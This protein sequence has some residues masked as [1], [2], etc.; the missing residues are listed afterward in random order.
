MQYIFHFLTNSI[1][2]K[3]QYQFNIQNSSYNK[4][5][6]ILMCDP[7]K[8]IHTPWIQFDEFLL[9]FVWKNSNN[10]FIH[11]IILFFVRCLVWFTCIIIIWIFFEIKLRKK[12]LKTVKLQNQSQYMDN[13]CIFD[14]LNKNAVI[15]VCGICEQW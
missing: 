7:I 9:F 2:S 13:I 6:S 8:L 1:Q 5:Y 4:I 10:L 12:K 15:M 11:F 3:I 14:C